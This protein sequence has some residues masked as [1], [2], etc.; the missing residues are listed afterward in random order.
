MRLKY[1]IIIAIIYSSNGCLKPKPKKKNVIFT[2]SENIVTEPVNNYGSNNRRDQ[3]AIDNQKNQTLQYNNPYPDNNLDKEI[4]TNNN[5]H[6]QIQAVENYKVAKNIKNSLMLKPGQFAYIKRGRLNKIIIG[7]IKSEEEA[8]LLRDTQHPGSFI[9][10]PENNE[11]ENSYTTNNDDLAG[12]KENNNNNPNSNYSGVAIQIGAF[13]SRE[14]AN[15]VSNEYQG[16]HNTKIIRVENNGNTLYKVMIIN[17]NTRDE[18]EAEQSNY[19]L[20]DSFIT[21]I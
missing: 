7:G 3:I 10:Y 19:N 21:Y 20:V 15:K 2:E 17:F 12:Y 4:K 8:I 11:L 1:F 13:S 9:V 6:L 14:T 16:T 18:A 5:I